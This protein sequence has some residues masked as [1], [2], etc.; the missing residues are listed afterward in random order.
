VSAE[1]PRVVGRLA[2]D[3]DPVVDAAVD[4]ALR[5]AGFQI[6]PVSFP[7][8]DKVLAA[9]MTV[10]EAEAW[11]SDQAL[12]ATAPDL[13]G[14]DVLRRLRAASGTT[15]AAVA[16]AKVELDKWRADL[17]RLWE[18]IDLLALPTLLGFPPTLEN[19]QDIHRIRGLTSPINAAGLPALALPVPS[20]GPLPASVQLIGPGGSEEQL[21][22]A[23]ALVEQA[24]RA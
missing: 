5:A 24:V 6:V 7:M 3:A 15:P 23:G 8:L 18:E 1:I 12:V 2:L 19:A 17:A 4:A 14:D 16:A 20:G 21:L 13:I 22:A 10:L 9:A 11:A